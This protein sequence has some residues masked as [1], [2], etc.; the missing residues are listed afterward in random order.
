LLTRGGRYVSAG[1]IEIE[2]DGKMEPASVSF[3]YRNIFIYHIH[4]SYS[5]AYKTEE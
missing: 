2:D 4:I 5:D 3:F 1:D